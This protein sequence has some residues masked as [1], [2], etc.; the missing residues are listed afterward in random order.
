MTQS[1]DIFALKADIAEL[2]RVVNLKPG[3]SP[4]AHAVA[5]A[6]IVNAR[7]AV[8][9]AE[10]VTQSMGTVRI[11]IVRPLVKAFAEFSAAASKLTA[12]LKKLP[13]R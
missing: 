6:A 9:A 10:T 11:N 7:S 4:D 2:R 13:D 12:A 1:G 3:L 5:L 8:L